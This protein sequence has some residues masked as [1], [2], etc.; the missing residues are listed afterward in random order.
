VGGGGGG[1]GRGGG[2]GGWG[3]G[4]GGVGILPCS[5][6]GR[7]G[8]YIWVSPQTRAPATARGDREIDAVAKQRHGRLF[9]AVGPHF[10]LLELSIAL[11]SDGQRPFGAALV[12]AT[13][14]IDG[15]RLRPRRRCA[16]TPPV[17]MGECVQ[18]G[19]GRLRGTAEHCD[20]DP[21]PLTGEAG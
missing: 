1:G 12:A 6:P 13:R 7:H 5:R 15:S 2:G 19:C 18:L 9:M 11:L 10:K 17:F 8:R 3:G 20:Q 4:G 21:R 14:S 16:P